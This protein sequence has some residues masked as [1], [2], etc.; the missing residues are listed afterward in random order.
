MSHPGCLRLLCSHKFWFKDH[1]SQMLINLS[2]WYTSLAP[3]VLKCGN[4]LNGMAIMAAGILP[5]YSTNFMPVFKY[6]MKVQSKRPLTWNNA[7]LKPLSTLMWILPMF[8]FLECGYPQGQLITCKVI[9]LCL[10]V[11]YFNMKGFVHDRDCPLDYQTLLDA[12]YRNK[13]CCHTLRYKEMGH[14]NRGSHSNSRCPQVWGI[15]SCP[16]WPR[17]LAPATT[18]TTMKTETMNSTAHRNVQKLQTCP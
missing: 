11:K 10:A 15:L 8:F 2:K 16:L 6:L 1:K 3:K 12:T 17:W 13:V 5:K 4:L 14:P 18:E 7:M 9:V